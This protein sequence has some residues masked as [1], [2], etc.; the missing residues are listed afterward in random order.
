M[1]EFG[2]LVRGFE[3]FGGEAADDRMRIRPNLC[4]RLIKCLKE[5]FGVTLP[6]SMQVLTISLRLQRTGIV[7]SGFRY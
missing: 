1:P 5:F 3:N 7:L 6:P 2:L 4:S